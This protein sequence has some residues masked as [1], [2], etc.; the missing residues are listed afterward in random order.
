M[1]IPGAPKLVAFQQLGG[2]PVG[3][4]GCPCLCLIPGESRGL[5]ELWVR[6]AVWGFSMGFHLCDEIPQPRRAQIPMGSP[7]WELWMHPMGHGHIPWVVDAPCG[8]WMDYGSIPGVTN[9]SQGS[10]IHPRGYECTLW[11]MDPFHGLWIHSI[12]YGSI[13]RVMDA[14]CR[15]WIHLSSYGSIPQIVDPSPRLFPTP[16]PTKVRPLTFLPLSPFPSL[17]QPLEQLRSLRLQELP[18]LPVQ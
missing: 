1:L 11:V 3:G 15:L 5:L 14:P 7:T 4:K 17:F 12:G 10:W 2:F 13:P 9:V 18:L 6:V 8:S 16:F